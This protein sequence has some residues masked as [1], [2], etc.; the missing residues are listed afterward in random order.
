MD[1]MVPPAL[2][3]PKE[4]KEPKEEDVGALFKIGVI[5]LF[6]ILMPGVFLLVN[7][8]VA[9]SL[10]WHGASNPIQQLGG[11]ESL[12]GHVV[13]FFV[14][15]LA[16]ILLRLFKLDRVDRCSAWVTGRFVVKGHDED[17]WRAAQ[18]DFLDIA[19]RRFGVEKEALLPAGCVPG[20]LVPV[21]PAPII[22]EQ[23]K[24]L[25]G[26]S[27]L[28]YLKLVVQ[29]RSVPLAEEVH[30]AEALM[31][32]L[33]GVF[34]ACTIS[35]LAY[36]AVLDAAA[37]RQDPLPVLAIA[38]IIMTVLIAVAIA[39]RFRSLR[40]KELDTVLGA[41]IASGFPCT[42]TGGGAATWTP[43]LAS[44]APTTLAGTPSAARQPAP[45]SQA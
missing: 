13:L 41:C 7:L 45:P 23:R 37:I 27:P 43:A 35:G 24:G 11:F 8:R 2:A 31:R 1:G 44:S 6:G 33:S 17:Y 21:A 20:T 26:K 32:L 14:A 19:R 39:S 18:F 5:D 9:C 30:K 4:P 15:Y 10:A 16:G 38:G 29:A 22:P 40:I 36:V 28:N 34:Y 42:V 12:V 3:S 25:S